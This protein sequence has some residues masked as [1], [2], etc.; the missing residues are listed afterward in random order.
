[1]DKLQ[2]TGK[3]YDFAL[4]LKKGWEKE[5]YKIKEILLKR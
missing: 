5:R 2:I 3:N 4:R 1:V